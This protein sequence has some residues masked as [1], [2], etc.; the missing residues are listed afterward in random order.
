[1]APL[2]LRISAL[3]LL[4]ILSMLRLQTEP[5]QIVHMGR[6]Q[7]FHRIRRAVIDLDLAVILQ[8]HPSRKNHMIAEAPANL[9]VCLRCQQ[10]LPAHADHLA[11]VL[12]IQQHNSGGIALLP[13]VLPTLLAT[14]RVHIHRMEGGQ[15]A[16]I[17]P[18]R[19]CGRANLVIGKRHLLDGEQ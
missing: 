12:Q 15:P 10:R 11:G 13:G 16:L 2:L 3:S 6:C 8:N 14:G 9:I 7:T 17:R 5:E 4:P 18:D 19:R 1:M